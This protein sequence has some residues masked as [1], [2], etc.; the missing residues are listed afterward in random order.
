MGKNQKSKIRN[1]NAYG[2]ATAN[3]RYRSSLLEKIKKKI[4]KGMRK[5]RRVR[6]CYTR[7]VCT[8]SE[9]REREKERPITWPEQEEFSFSS[10]S[11]LEE[12]GRKKSKCDRFK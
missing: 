7:I 6:A 3:V 9:I 4:R 5:A 1:K 2:R 11:H 12:K 10:S 8:R